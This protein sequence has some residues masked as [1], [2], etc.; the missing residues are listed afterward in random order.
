MFGKK[1]NLI[2][3]LDGNYNIESIALSRLVINS[4]SP[5]SRYF[6]FCCLSVFTFLIVKQ[7]SFYW[8]NTL[9]F[10]AEISYGVASSSTL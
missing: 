8:E 9:L 7:P 6:F 10:I 4:L 2:V 1:L 5:I 3:G